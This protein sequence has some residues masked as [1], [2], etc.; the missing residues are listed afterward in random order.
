[1]FLYIKSHSIPVNNDKET[2]FLG[3]YTCH[4]SHMDAKRIHLILII[5]TSYPFF[6]PIIFSSTTL[7]TCRAEKTRITLT[8]KWTIKSLNT[9]TMLIAYIWRAH[10]FK[11]RYYFKYNE[12]HST[13]AYIYNTYSVHWSKCCKVK[14]WEELVWT[15]TMPRICCLI[16]QFNKCSEIKNKKTWKRFLK[17]RYCSSSW[18]CKHCPVYYFQSLNNSDVIWSSIEMKWILKWSRDSLVSCKKQW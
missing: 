17:K 2:H 7:I 9:Y 1:L 5:Q 15:W 16:L 10:Y 12:L 13:H 18:R 6:T 14:K 8:S 3:Q 4:Y 11:N